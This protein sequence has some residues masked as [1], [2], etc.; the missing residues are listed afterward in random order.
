M[1]AIHR[2]SIDIEKPETTGR[3]ESS[4]YVFA[5]YDVD[6]EEI[7][8]YRGAEVAMILTDLAT[9]ILNGMYCEAMGYDYEP[10]EGE[11]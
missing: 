11:A 6:G 2:I 3:A 5:A 9:S 10:S 1:K 8:E 7:L 4:E